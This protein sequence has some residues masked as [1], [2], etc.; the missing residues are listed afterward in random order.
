ML[1]F[2]ITRV[3]EDAFNKKKWKY[4]SKCGQRAKQTTVWILSKKCLIDQSEYS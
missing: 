1:F 3:D 2:N 4:E